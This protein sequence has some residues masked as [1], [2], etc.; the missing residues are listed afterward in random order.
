MDAP[1]LKIQDMLQEILVRELH[2][3]GE[4]RAAVWFQDTWTKEHG[5]YT[6]ASAGYCGNR[7]SAGCEVRWRYMLRDTVGTC[8]T[9][10]RVSMPV[11]GP[12]MVKYVG[13][14]SESVVEKLLDAESGV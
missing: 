6:N 4:H 2:S 11:F 12:C 5:N 10:Q 9:T 1:S 14:L 13:D 8:G 3:R 7:T